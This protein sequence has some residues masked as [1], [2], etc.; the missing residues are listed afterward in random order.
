MYMYISRLACEQ[1]THFQSSLLS[2]RKIAE[3]E[4]EATTGN[5]PAV[6]RLYLGTHLT[7]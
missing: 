4:G 3:R 2:L 1:Q 6:R 7:I 5:A